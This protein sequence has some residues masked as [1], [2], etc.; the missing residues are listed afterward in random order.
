M[1]CWRTDCVVSSDEKLFHKGREI[2]SFWVAKRPIA[3]KIVKF[4]WQIALYK[5]KD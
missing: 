2:K 1:N 5:C 4:N 3:Q